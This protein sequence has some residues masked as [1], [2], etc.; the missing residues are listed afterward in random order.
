MKTNQL[1][2]HASKSCNVCAEELDEQSD[3]CLTALLDSII[4]STAVYVIEIRNYTA[5]LKSS[6]TEIVLVKSEGNWT[7]DERAAIQK[8]NKN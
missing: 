5:Y 6:L 4:D 8:I 7:G 3:N 1:M 2:F